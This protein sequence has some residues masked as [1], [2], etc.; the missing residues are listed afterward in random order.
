MGIKLVDKKRNVFNVEVQYSQM[1]DY[2]GSGGTEHVLAYD[3]EFETEHFSEH[4]LPYLELMVTYAGGL[5]TEEEPLETKT[6]VAK[7]NVGG[8]I[9]QQ[10]WDKL[11][12]VGLIEYGVEYLEGLKIEHIDGNG[13]AYDVVVSVR[14]KFVTGEQET[15]S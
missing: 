2:I 14:P 5:P 12:E 3:G 15:E 4:V 6:P 11:I 8:K 1:G 7:M 10:V 9:Y 13:R